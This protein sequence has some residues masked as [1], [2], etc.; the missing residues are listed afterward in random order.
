M[1]AK[2]VTRQMTVTTATVM[3]VNKTTGAT[4]DREERLSGKFKNNDEVLKSL[5]KLYK[6][7]D[8]QPVFIKSVSE[9]NFLYG[10]KEN[11]FIKMAV[12]LDENRNP[13][14]ADEKPVED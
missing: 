13:I 4:E 10:M 12:R 2:M 7:T 6:N 8:I 5:V 1:R 9:D 11:D 14:Y 3:M